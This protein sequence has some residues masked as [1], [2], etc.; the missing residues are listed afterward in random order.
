MKTVTCDYCK[1]L[2]T[3]DGVHTEVLI[4]RRVFG[5]EQFTAKPI[6]DFHSPCAEEFL[7]KIDH[8]SNLPQRV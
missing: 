4:S 7:R 8:V 2:I 5:K 6:K 3:V 1:E